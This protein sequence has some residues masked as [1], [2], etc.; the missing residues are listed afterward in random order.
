MDLLPGLREVVSE[1]LLGS[2]TEHSRGPQ[3]RREEA[4]S[5]AES[6]VDGHGEV[7]SGSGVAVGGRVH[8]LDTGHGENLLWNERSHDAGATRSGDET[9]TNRTTLASNLARHSMWH[10][11]VITPVSSTNRNEVHLGIDDASSNGSG[12]FLSALETQS[13]MTIPISNSDIALESSTLSCSGLLLYG[14]DLHH[15][16]LDARAEVIDDLVLLDREGEEEDLLDALDLPVLHQSSQLGHWY[17]LVLV[18]SAVSA[19]STTSSS[20]PTPSIAA[21]TTKSSSSLACVSHGS[22]VSAGAEPIYL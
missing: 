15:L 11:R 10:P 6:G 4:V 19:S 18:T 16:V 3:L 21:T 13:D 8:V 1:L 22:L 7:S 9:N 12:N 20:I 5:L 2:G 14:H 17:P